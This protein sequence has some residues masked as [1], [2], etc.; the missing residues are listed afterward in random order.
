MWQLDDVKNRWHV[1]LLFRRLFR[2]IA[3]LRQQYIAA[4]QLM[5]FH[6]Q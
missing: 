5:T 2:G 4:A 6:V 1:L 3:V